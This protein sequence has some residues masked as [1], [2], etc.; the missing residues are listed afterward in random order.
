MINTVSP[1]ITLQVFRMGWYQGLG[2]RAFT[3]PTT[4]NAS[5]QPGPLTDSATGLTECNW[6]SAYTLTVPR[7]W[8]S[9]VYLVKMTAMSTGSQG[10]IPFVVTDPSSHSDLAYQLPTFTYQAYNYWGGKSFYGS[11]Q[12]GDHAVKVSFHRPYAQVAGSGYIMDDLATVRFLEKHGYDVSY[13]T[14]YDVHKGTVSLTQHKALLSGGHGEYWTKEMRDSV[15]SARDAGVHLAMFSGNQIYWQ[16]RVEQST[17]TGADDATLVCYKGLSDPYATDPSKSYLTTVLWRSSLLKKPE[18]LLMG[19]QYVGLMA[20]GQRFDMVI[21]EP[22]SWVFD[23]TGLAQG[24]HLAGLIRN[25]VNGHY[26]TTGPSDVSVLAHSP[27]MASDGTTRYSDMTVYTAPSGAIVFDA[28]T[29]F[30]K[31]GL[32]PIKPTPFPPATV[33]AVQQITTNV[34]AKFG[35]TPKS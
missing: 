27:F 16:V 29:T 10:F 31:N 33:T 13:V 21:A 1:T 30:W 7:K 4:I 14:D 34:L 25:E 32:E 11:V 22:N 3:D 18:Q 9:G 2:G 5:P 26:S 24:D 6:K 12:N 17:L 20:D 35:A 15:T 19:S 8:T 28:S 23:K